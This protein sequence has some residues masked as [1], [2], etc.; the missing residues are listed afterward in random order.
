MRTGGVGGAALRRQHRSMAGEVA[1]CRDPGGRVAALS[2]VLREPGHG[3]WIGCILLVYGKLAK[4]RLAAERMFFFRARPRLVLGNPDG[5]ADGVP[6]EGRG[7]C[8]GSDFVLR[9]WR[10][11][12]QVVEPHCRVTQERQRGEPY[13]MTFKRRGGELQ[14]SLGG[15]YQYGAVDLASRIGAFG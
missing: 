7:P 10:Q 13:I 6:A 12:I 3:R 1:Q 2:R 14:G 15:Q 8:G 4:G 11:R 9:D 5:V